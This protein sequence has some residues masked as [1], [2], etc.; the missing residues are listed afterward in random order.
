MSNPE[1]L[2]QRIIRDNTCYVELACVSS[3]TKP[4]ENIA[5]GSVLIEVD[6][7]K[8]YLF[9]ASSTSSKWVEM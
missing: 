5:T 7:K 1:V 6:T 4:E 3:D 9:N 2:Y 8:V